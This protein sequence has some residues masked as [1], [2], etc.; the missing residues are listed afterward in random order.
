MKTT[1]VAIGN[2]RGVR[3]PKPFIEQCAFGTEAFMTVEQGAVVIRP[4]R[5]SRSGWGEAFQKMAEQ[6]DDILIDETMSASKWD[7][8]EW[9]WK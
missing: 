3:I 6:K 9:E 2:S 4:A 5:K 1:L 7:A 8:S